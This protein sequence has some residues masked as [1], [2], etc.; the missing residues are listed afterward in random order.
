MANSKITKE[1][2]LRVNIVG[3][4]GSGKSTFA[5][6][7]AQQLN[8][9]HIEMDLLFWRPN[10]TMPSDEDFF[11]QIEKAVSQERWVLDGNYG[12]SQDI[13]WKNATAVIWLNYSFSRTLY[14]ICWRAIHRSWT[15]E[16]LWP[17]TNNRETL[18]RAFFSRKE[19]IVVWMIQNYSKIQSRYQLAAENPKYSHVLFIELKS[20]RDARA[21]LDFLK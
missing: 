18:R 16:E 2:L 10:W 8:S 19:S 17:G 7:L 15:G 9:P 5:K 3:S 13:K 11:P 20:P 1:Q 12:R 14:Q 4:S 21:F 6:E